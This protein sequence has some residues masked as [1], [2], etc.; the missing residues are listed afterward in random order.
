VSVFEQVI[1]L[2]EFDGGAGRD[3][4]YRVAAERGDVEALKP[5]GDFKCCD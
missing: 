5:S 1:F 2:D 4:C 3:A